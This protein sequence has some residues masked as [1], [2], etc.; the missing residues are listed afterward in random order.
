MFRTIY[1][2]KNKD[3]ENLWTF[4]REQKISVFPITATNNFSRPLTKIHEMHHP[5][6]I[7]NPKNR[8]VLSSQSK[9]CFSVKN[10]FQNSKKEEITADSDYFFHN[11]KKKPSLFDFKHKKEE[12][13]DQESNDISVFF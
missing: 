12:F 11:F 6:K 4:P 7:K 2:F 3:S 9:R 13:L 10:L 5:I 1:N 8:V